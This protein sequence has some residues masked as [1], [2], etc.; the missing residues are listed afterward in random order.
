MEVCSRSILRVSEAGQAIFD[1]SETQALN[2]GIE[3]IPVSVLPRKENNAEEREAH[4]HLWRPA[5]S[6]L[7]ALSSIS[8]IKLIGKYDASEDFHRV[9]RALYPLHVSYL[10]LSL[11]ISICKTLT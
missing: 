2:G 7:Q 6:R 9:N 4:W 5:H 1:E 10:L 8:S 3:C 11:L